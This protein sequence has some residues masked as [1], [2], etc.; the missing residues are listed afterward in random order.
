[1]EEADFRTHPQRPVLQVVAEPSGRM[2]PHTGPASSAASASSASTAGTNAYWARLSE[3]MRW[4]SEGRLSESEFA[5]AK[6]A[7]GL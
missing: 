5:R 7:M 6:A 3:L 1:M 2:L 4:H